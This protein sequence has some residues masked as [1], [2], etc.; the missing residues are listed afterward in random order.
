MANTLISSMLIMVVVI[1][2]LVALLLIIKIKLTP[3]GTVTIDINDGKKTLEVAPGENLMATLAN[4]K[5]FLPS[6]CGGKA[7]CGQCKV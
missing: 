3:S 7:N 6:A 2:I 4:Q 1:L 5:I